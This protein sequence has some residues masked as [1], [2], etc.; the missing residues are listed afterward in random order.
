ME[1]L[2]MPLAVKLLFTGGIA[3]LASLL[4]VLSYGYDGPPA[5]VLKVCHRLLRVGV[6]TALSGALWGIWS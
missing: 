1:P 5:R 6:A 3:V 2:P 4:T